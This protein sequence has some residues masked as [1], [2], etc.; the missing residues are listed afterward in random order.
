MDNLAEMGASRNRTCSGYHVNRLT[1]D[2]R[3]A[4]R[5]GVFLYYQGP[6]RMATLSETG[7]GLT[8]GAKVWKSCEGRH[9]PVEERINGDSVQVIL[10]TECFDCFLPRSSNS[11]LLVELASC[12]L[13][14]HAS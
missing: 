7:V 1:G 14:L 12:C 6:F 9:P 13:E 11:T 3:G 4:Q 10:E 8:K 5:N 2:S